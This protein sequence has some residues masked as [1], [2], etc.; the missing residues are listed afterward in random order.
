VAEVSDALD[1]CALLRRLPPRKAPSVGARES[2]TA[3]LDAVA[4]EGGLR[5]HA[6]GAPGRGER[7]RLLAKRTAA[8]RDRGM[9]TELCGKQ[10]C[11]CQPA[12]AGELR[13][14][15]TVRPNAEDVITGHLALALRVL[16]PRRWLPDL[17]NAAPG[18]G[19]FRR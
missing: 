13:C 9:P 4:A 5:Y 3:F 6:A 17:L 7:I 14:P 1:T 2:L 18:S 11:V 19:R 16:D 15:L 8:P 12:R 10:G